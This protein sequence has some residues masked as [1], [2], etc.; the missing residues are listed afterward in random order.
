[1]LKRL[2]PLLL[3]LLAVVA[4]FASGATRY[5]SLES[6]QTHEAL[7]RGFVADN[8]ALS[9]LVFIGVYAAATAVSIPGALILTLAG[10][11]LFGTWLGGAATVIGATIGAILV[12]AIVRTSLGAVLRERAE[13]SGGKLK[14]VMDGV[15]DGAFGYILTLRLIPLAPF[16]LVNVASALAN[17]PLRAYALATLIGIMPGTF[18]YSSVGAGIGQVLARGGEPN[19]KIIFEPYVI[20]PLVALGLL[21]LGTTLF[22]RLRG[23]E[24]SIS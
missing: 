15:R 18:I 19:L 24:G 14:A 5:L 6:L 4:V 20:G 1:M 11:F 3:L 17:A 22:Q 16:W 21:S 12:F 13:A 8:L 9:I 10:G 2:M 7:L 23:R